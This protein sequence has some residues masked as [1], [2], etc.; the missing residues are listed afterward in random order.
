MTCIRVTSVPGTEIPGVY[1]DSTNEN[2]RCDRGRRRR[3]FPTHD[4][5]PRHIEDIFLPNR[6]TL[7]NLHDYQHAR[8][9]LWI[10][11]NQRAPLDYLL[12]LETLFHSA[13]R[14]NNEA[15]LTPHTWYRRNDIRT[16]RLIELKQRE[17]R[18]VWPTCE[19]PPNLTGRSHLSRDSPS[20]RTNG[21]SPG[22]GQL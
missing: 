8:G 22:L 21:E 16:Y 4:V 10:Y 18:A 9:I 20:G 3:Y 5:V 17:T 19:H 13:G 12:T 14:L 7:L 2:T 1:T 15:R 11:W 6:W